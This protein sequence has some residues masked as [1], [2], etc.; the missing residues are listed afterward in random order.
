MGESRVKWTYFL[1]SP[2]PNVIEKA[3]D[4]IL[5]SIYDIILWP[6]IPATEPREI[7][8]ISHNFIEVGLDLRSI[9]FWRVS[10]YTFYNFIFAINTIYEIAK[11]HPCPA[12]LRQ[13]YFQ[14]F[15]LLFIH[16]FQQ[17][18]LIYEPLNYPHFKSIINYLL[19]IALFGHLPNCL[20]DFLFLSSCYLGLNIQSF[21]F[22]HHIVNILI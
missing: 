14:F 8:E 11:H 17:P 18:D 21:H 20:L 6:Q 16:A 22:A 9:A 13:V 12:V 1:M 2:V 5:I 7:F 15:N 3:P 19:F 10:I 4:D